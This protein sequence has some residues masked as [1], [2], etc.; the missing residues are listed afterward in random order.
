MKILMIGLIV[1]ALLGGC[2]G[3]GTTGSESASY[4]KNILSK[5]QRQIADQIISIFENDTPVLQYGYSKNLGDGR[6]ITAGRAGFTSATADMLE[7]IERYSKVDPENPLVIYIPRLKE[8]AKDVDSSTK[9]LEGLERKWKKLGEEKKFRGVQDAVVDDFYYN[10][11]V[12][13]A[14]QLGATY[15]LTMLNLYDAV[16]QH[17]DG[18]DPDGLSAMI[19]RATSKV[20]NTPANGTDEKLWLQAFMDTRRAVLINPRNKDTQAEWSDSVGRVDALI[21]LY[22]SGNVSL[23]PPIKMNAWGQEYTLPYRVKNI[24]K[25]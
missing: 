6:G 14:K 20:G 13:R 12:A 18:E 22:N 11:A 5:E 17:G 2:G 19:K 24:L 21:R 8:L 10:A 3:K 9:G 7:V 23:T 4:G 16:I 15:P 1:L 25:E